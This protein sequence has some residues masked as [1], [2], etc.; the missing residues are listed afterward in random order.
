MNTPE[1]EGGTYPSTL[2]DAFTPVGDVTELTVVPNP[3]PVMEATASSYVSPQLDESFASATKTPIKQT[4]SSAPSTGITREKLHTLQLQ[5]ERLSVGMSSPSPDREAPSSSSSSVSGIIPFIKMIF[6]RPP[7]KPAD[8][9]LGPVDKF[10]KYGRIPVKMSLNIIMVLLLSVELTMYVARDNEYYNHSALGLSEMFSPNE[11]VED[12]PDYSYHF[13]DIRNVVVFMNDTFSSWEDAPLNPTAL[14]SH[15]LEAQA[16]VMPK[17]TLDVKANGTYTDVIGQEDADLDTDTI[18][19]TL[20]PS[21]PMGPFTEFLTDSLDSGSDSTGDP[22]FCFQKDVELFQKVNRMRIDMELDSV[23]ADSPTGNPT[24]LRWHISQEYSMASRSGVVNFQLSLTHSIVGRFSAKYKGDTFAS[25]YCMLPLFVI[26][27]A[28]LDLLLRFKACRRE[29]RFTQTMNQFKK[30]L[31]LNQSRASPVALERSERLSATPAPI[32]EPLLSPLGDE[33]KKS[34]G[35]P[36]ERSTDSPIEKS[37]S[38]TIRNRSRS[39]RGMSLSGVSAHSEESIASARNFGMEQEVHEGMHDGME[40]WLIDDNK[41][42]W[43]AICFFTDLLLITSKML[44]LYCA[45][46]TNVVNSDTLI[47]KSTISGIAVAM[48]WIVLVSHLENQP[49][50]YLLM[51]T[52]R[53]GTP[54]ALRFTAGCFPIL[55]GYALLGTV[56]FGGYAD[57][58]GSL[59]ASF[60]VLFSLMNGDIIDETF[61]S[62]FFEGNLFLKIFSRLYLYTFIALFVYA[63]LNIL[64]VILEDAYFLVKRQVIEGI[65][66]G[67]E[68]DE[69]GVVIQTDNVQLVH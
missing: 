63:I 19:C 56:M 22:E 23:R 61:D 6:Q 27:C 35:T 17:M 33:G 13:Y 26:I 16:A 32:E 44:H 2:P 62:I 50:F 59:D 58:F 68:R 69:E 21:R 11:Q 52:L 49:R 20:T 10:L 4:A 14:F 55:M 30:N 47:V 53:R 36:S 48:A 65:K 1:S 43:L 34:F 9:H 28:V 37:E 66:E 42:Q 54:K 67:L 38:I 3:L 25:G 60:V 41:R 12:N 64:L 31:L 8:K 7:I 39:R 18:V 46:T 5:E 15:T 24:V 51:K 57:R 40:W 29:Y 45:L